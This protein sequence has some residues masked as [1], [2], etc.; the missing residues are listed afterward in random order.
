M[1]FSLHYVQNKV[2]QPRFWISIHGDHQS[3]RKTRRKMRNWTKGNTLEG[4]GATLYDTVE[5][6]SC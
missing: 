6:I 3:K 4:G 5:V 2:R 1:E